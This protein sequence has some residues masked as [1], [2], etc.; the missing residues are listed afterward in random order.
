MQVTLQ[1]SPADELTLRQMADED[2]YDSIE[3]LIESWVEHQAGV[4]R[5]CYVEA[6]H[7]LRCSSCQNINFPDYTRAEIEPASECCKCGKPL[8]AELDVFVSRR[9]LE[10]GLGPVRKA[11]AS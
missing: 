2:A 6:A 5:L 11:V 1:I 7:I 10:R 4:H 9:R 3:A 8:N